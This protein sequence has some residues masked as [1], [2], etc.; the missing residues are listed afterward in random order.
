MPLPA[1]A[2]IN[3]GVERTH[4]HI[5]GNDF[6]FILTPGVQNLDLTPV[7]STVEPLNS[8]FSYID[9]LPNDSDSTYTVI[10]Y[11]LR[12]NVDILISFTSA[13]GNIPSIAN[14]LVWSTGKQLLLK[15]SRDALAHIYNPRGTLV[16]TIAIQANQLTQIPLPTGFY[17]VMLNNQFYKVLI[18]H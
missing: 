4:Y 15:S 13:D 10:I 8:P 1:G 14:D 18:T 9:I 2:T 7:V 11:R 16:Q 12:E 3:Y 5:S 6:T 17:F